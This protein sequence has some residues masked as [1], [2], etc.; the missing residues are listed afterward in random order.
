M[1]SNTQQTEN[2]WNWKSE[3]N[4]KTDNHEIWWWSLFTKLLLRS[5]LLAI[6][7]AAIT[8]FV[9]EIFSLF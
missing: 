4:D 5:I 7:V 6:G 3:V 8:G 1:K 2:S 9:F